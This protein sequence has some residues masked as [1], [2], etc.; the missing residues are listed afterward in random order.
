MPHHPTLGQTFTIHTHYKRGTVQL[1]FHA[2]GRFWEVTTFPEPKEGIY[3]GFRTLSNGETDAYGNYT[4]EK[5]F[6]AALIIFSETT[7]GVYVPWSQVSG[8]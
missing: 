8:E 2:E 3:A 5:S 4:K 7:N 6:K 1:P